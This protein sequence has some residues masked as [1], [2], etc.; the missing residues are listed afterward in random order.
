MA[1]TSR[2]PADSCLQSDRI[3]N[4]HLQVLVGSL[5][6]TNQWWVGTLAGDPPRF[7]PERVGILDYGNGNLF[8]FA[9]ALCHA[10]AL[11]LVRFGSVLAI[12]R[13]SM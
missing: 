2:H 12:R 8:F 1:R 4:P 13:N 10:D 5:Y 3:P 11:Y 7:T 9:Y 6:K